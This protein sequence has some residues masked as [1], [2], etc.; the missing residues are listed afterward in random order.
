MKK[1][2]F[3]I[4]LLLTAI[5]VRSQDVPHWTKNSWRNTQYP[6]DEYFT[7]FSQDVKSGDEKVSEATERVKD[8]ARASLSK[9]VITQIRS[10]SESYMQS[11]ETGGNESIKKT[12]EKEVKA[13]TD[14]E[15]NGVKV[16]SYYNKNN[17]NVYAFAYAKRND[18]ISYYKSKISSNIQKIESLM[19]SAEEF[20]RKSEKSE[21]VKE[22]EKCIPLFAKINYAQGLLMAVDRNA[23]DSAGLDMQKSIKLHKKFVHELSEVK[24][25]YI[26][27][28][29]SADVFDEETDVLENKLKAA[30]AG[31]ECTFTADTSGADFLI[32]VDATAREYNHAYNTYFSY[33]DA[34][35][36]IK[37][38]YNGEQIYQDEISQKGGS[39]KSYTSAAK[40]AFEDIID[41]IKDKLLNNIK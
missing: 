38:A 10:V 21:A 12:F 3:I 30:L 18:V 19:K 8:M 16:K 13:E 22:Y 36:D 40:E 25:T 37:K 27:L 11:V 7:G 17:D 23:G 1:T 20:S 15:I 41:K 24:D 34:R 5:S 39:T 35:V 4:F 6:A 31:N 29:I 32:S 33:V 2:G 14:A 28:D 26:H 9:S